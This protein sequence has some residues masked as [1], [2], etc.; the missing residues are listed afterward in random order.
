[1]IE[2]GVANTSILA[3]QPI[4]YELITEGEIDLDLN[5]K[6]YQWHKDLPEI[7]NYYREIEKTGGDKVSRTIDRH[8]HTNGLHGLACQFHSLPVQTA[9]P[10]NL[11]KE[12]GDE[13]HAN[14]HVAMQQSD[15]FKMTTN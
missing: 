10:P 7:K 3:G 2:N 1:M 9:L 11:K 8:N 14:K 13:L 15:S 12:H 6:Q 5:D 4:R